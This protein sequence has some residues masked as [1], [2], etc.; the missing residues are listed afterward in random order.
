MSAP[1]LARDRLRAAARVLRA[2]ADELERLAEQVETGPAV[3]PAPPATDLRIWYAARAATMARS[4]E[5][6]D[7]RAAAAAGFA[8][9]RAALRD[10][11]RELAPEAWSRPGRPEAENLAAGEI[12]ERSTAR[13]QPVPMARSNQ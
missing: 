3:E 4:S 11:R 10:L 6:D 13:F 8:I 9:G 12:S 2:E 1:A 5:A 7:L